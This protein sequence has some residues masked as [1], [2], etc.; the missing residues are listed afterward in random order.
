MPFEKKK[1]YKTFKDY[2]QKNIYLD[3]A[4]LYQAE[5][6][7]LLELCGHKQSKFMGLLAHDFIQTM[8]INL[9]LLDK[10]SF[11]KIMG[12][13]ELQVSKGM[14][15]PFAQMGA[16]FQPMMAQV[17][18]QTTDKITSI[19]T[20]QKPEEVIDYPEDDLIKEEDMDA[21]N[22]ALKAFGA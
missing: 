5:C 10:D 20:G 19:K 6:C 12:L 17:P 16:I 7:K 4:D 15:N 14:N 13:Y 22:D 1:K 2:R 11:K 18:Y 9:E 3:E 21:L 8:G